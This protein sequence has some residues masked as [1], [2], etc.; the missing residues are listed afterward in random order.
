MKDVSAIYLNWLIRTVQDTDGKALIH[1]KLI[2]Q[3][4]RT[5]FLVINKKDQS[6][7]NDGVDLRWRF[8]WETMRSYDEIEDITYISDVPDERCS[9]LEMMVALAFRADEDFTKRKNEKSTVPLIFWDMVRNLGLLEQTDNVYDPD[10]VARVLQRFNNREYER[11]GKGGL[12]SFKNITDD[13][14]EVEIWYQLCWYINE[15]NL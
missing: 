13:M 8:K 6:R 3:L 1:Q 2:R 12:F 4:H 5:P 7:E 14:R 15:K 11:N 9:L 10:E